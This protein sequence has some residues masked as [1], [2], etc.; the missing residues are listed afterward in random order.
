[1]GSGWSVRVVS[2]WIGSGDHEDEGCVVL[3]HVCDCSTYIMVTH[4]S[5]FF[6]N[7]TVSPSNVLKVWIF[8][9]ACFIVIDAMLG[10]GPV[11]SCS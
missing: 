4:K 11:F 6:S 7:T 10:V 1:V 2:Q 8:A 3:Q 9:R 5:Q